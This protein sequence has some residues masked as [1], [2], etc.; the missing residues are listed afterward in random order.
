MSVRQREKERER[1]K[2]SR[3][4]ETT[5]ETFPTIEPTYTAQTI[6]INSPNCNIKYVH[7]GNI[8]FQ[9]IEKRDRKNKSL[10]QIPVETKVREGERERERERGE[11]SDYTN[12][13]SN[14]NLMDVR[15]G[16]A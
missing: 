9:T 2:R 16:L 5:R 4:F 7:Q 13:V 11:R 3:Q 10:L 12:W 6:I 8:R 1:E 14:K 15:L